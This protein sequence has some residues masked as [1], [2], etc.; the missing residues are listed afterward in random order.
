MEIKDIIEDRKLSTE[1]KIILL[2]AEIEKQIRAAPAEEV[3]IRLICDEVQ[4]H[5]YCAAFKPRQMLLKK[6]G[7]RTWHRLLANYSPT[8]GATFPSM[9]Q[10]VERSLKRQRRSA[11]QKVTEV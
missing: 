11:F 1:A 6:N 3:E 4:F 9:V 10:P 8:H 7:Q 2:A 5:T